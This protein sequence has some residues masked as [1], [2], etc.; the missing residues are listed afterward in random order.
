MTNIIRVFLIFFLLIPGA[1][2]ADSYKKVEDTATSDI[3]EITPVPTNV[4]CT[5]DCIIVE[6]TL[7]SDDLS[8]KCEVLYCSNELCELVPSSISNCK[9]V[10]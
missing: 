8:I 2:I 6:K 10:K 5:T 1:V 7:V 4:Y 3:V 9:I